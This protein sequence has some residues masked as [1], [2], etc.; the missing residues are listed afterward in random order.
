MKPKITLYSY[1]ASPYAQ[2]VRCYLLYKN[3]E[4]ETHYVNPLA[5]KQELPFGHLVPV[6]SCDDESRNESTE[7]GLWL[8]GLFLDLPL[9]PD[10]LRESIL[11]ADDWVSNQLI[12]LAFRILIGY[13][14]SVPT[15]VRKRW[16]AS[17][18]LKA[19]VP[20]GVPFSFRVKHL[21]FLGR[22]P[23]LQRILNEEDRD[24]TN[25]ELR[26]QCSEKF[27][28]LLDGGP[29]LCGSAKPTLADLSAFPQ[30]TFPLYCEGDDYLLHGSSASNWVGEMYKAVPNLRGF[31]PNEL[32]SAKS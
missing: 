14:D 15:M 31:I 12:P 16:A 21:L 25:L 24:R 11:E 18:I 13:G 29:F 30:I 32:H 19:T 10:E 17:R 9:L 27:E 3:L 4:F 23:M 26:H 1:A 22:A 28:E 2:K 20:V 7:I 6:L 8:D 5:I